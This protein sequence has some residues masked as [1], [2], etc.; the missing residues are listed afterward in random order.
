MSFAFEKRLVYQKAVDFSDRVCQLANGFPGGF[1]LFLPINSIARPSPLPPT[2][3]RA[4]AV[5]P[6]QAEGTSSA[7]RAALFRSVCRCWSW[8]DGEACWMIPITG[9]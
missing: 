2:W 5:S 8:R 1:W 4:T 7:S 6:R 9:S 3:P